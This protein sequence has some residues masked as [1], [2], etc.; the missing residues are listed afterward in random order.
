M[1]DRHWINYRGTVVQED[2][3]EKCYQDHI[4]WIIIS[5]RMPERNSG[6]TKIVAFIVKQPCVCRANEFEL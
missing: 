3:R 6:F 4:L 2:S 5:Y 1:T